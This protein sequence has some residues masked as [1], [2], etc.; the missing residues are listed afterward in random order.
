[1]K[2]IWTDAG[3]DPSW[4]VGD[5]YGIDG[6]FFPGID[7]LTPGLVVEAANRGHAHGIYIGENWFPGL[8]PEQYAAKVNGILKP[9]RAKLPKVRLQLNIEQGVQEVLEKLQA[10]RALQPTIG[11]SWSLMG[12]NGGLFT[13]GFVD[14]LLKLHVRI[15]PE[16]FW[17]ADGRMD[18]IYDSLAVQRDITSRLIPASL[19]TPMID[20]KYAGLLRGWDG[21]AFT[22]GRLPE[23]A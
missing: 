6:Y 14:W 7:P 5:A 3:D 10:M 22:M 21:Y 11:L 1:M 16:A 12:M 20:A 8:T 9:I 23:I 4:S 17:G 19:V 13:P 2:Y 18:G 15:V